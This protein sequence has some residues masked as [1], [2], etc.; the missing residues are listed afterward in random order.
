MDQ[1]MWATWYDLTDDARASY[2]D[3]AH[4]TYLPFLQQLPGYAWVAHY[5]YEGGGPKMER[6]KET[7]VSHT[8]EAVGEGTQYLLLV[9]AA[10]AHT[11]FKPAIS[12]IEWPAEFAHMLA[13]RQGVRTVIFTEEARVNGPAAAKA[14][15][16]STPGPAIQMGT[17]R[18]RS[19]DDEFEIGR[20]Y[21]QFRL[22][23]MA[24]MPGCIATRKLLG[25]A[26]WAKHGVLYEFESMEMR[27]KHFEEPHESLCLDSKHWSSRV[28]RTTVHAPG[29]PTIGTRIWPPVQ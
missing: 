23:Y 5:R 2:L 22:P 12:E 25:V 28:V 17:F 18:L 9:G 10:S 13:R 3:W 1:G 21:A 4:S 7:V 15:P 11:F 19:V 14:A 26:G 6:V 20:W 27:L 8:H 16:G 29:S 24:Q